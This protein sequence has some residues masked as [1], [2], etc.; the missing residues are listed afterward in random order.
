MEGRLASGP[1]PSH[2]DLFLIHYFSAMMK[3]LKTNGGFVNLEHDGGEEEEA[4][5]EPAEDSYEQVKV[6]I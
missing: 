4:L 1:S 5:S 3:S 6:I 2:P